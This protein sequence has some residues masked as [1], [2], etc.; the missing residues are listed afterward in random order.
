MQSRR[1]QNLKM[2]TYDPFKQSKTKPKIE[3]VIPEY[4]TGDNKQR[5]LDFATWL[6]TN[7]MSPAW[8]IT[9][10]WSNSII[11]HPITFI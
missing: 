1:R 5:A 10:G 8:K 2:S 9:N 11:L 7:K 3:E 6:R 4:L